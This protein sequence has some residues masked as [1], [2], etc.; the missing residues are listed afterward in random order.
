[1]YCT[2]CGVLLDDGVAYCSRCGAATGVR[3]AVLSPAP[4]ERLTLSIYDKKIAGVCG[5]MAQYLS[6]D[7]TLVRLIWL[8]CAICFP[9]LV[10]GY[11]AAWII[12]PR[13]AP[14]LAA[15]ISRARLCQAQPQ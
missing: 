10:L 4:N 7:S 15:P 13:E 1:M 9:P 2:K 14:R 6:V 11:I 12:V 3:S 8:V 5:G